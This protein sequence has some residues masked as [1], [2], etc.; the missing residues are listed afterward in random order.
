MSA[1][2]F[3][4][5]AL[6]EEGTPKK[7]FQ[8][9]LQPDD[10]M[11]YTDEYLWVVDQ[12]ARGRTI[13]RRRFQQ[14]FP[15]FEWV[16]PGERTQSLIEELKD[17]A[18]YMKLAS[19]LEQV[20]EDLSPDNFTTKA[21]F[22]REVTSDVLRQHSPASDVILNRDVAGYLRRMKDRQALRHNGEAIGISTGIK[23]LDIHLG[24]LLG[25]RTTLVLGRPGDAKSMTVAKVFVSGFLEGRVMA[26]FSPEMD[27]DEHRA[28]IA[29]LISAVPRVQEELGLQK[30]LRNR[31]LLDGTGYN[32]KTLKRLW[33]WIES[34]QGEMVLFTRKYR[35]FKMTPAFIES[36][37]ADMGVEAVFVDPIYKLR[38]SERMMK[39]SGWEKLNSIVDE[40]VDI[41]EGHNVPLWMTNQAHRQNGNRGDAP[42]KDNSFGS[43]SPVQEADAVIGVKHIPDEKKLIIRCT[44]NRWGESFRVDLKFLPNI[45]KIEDVTRGENHYYNGHED[46]SEERTRESMREMEKEMG[47]DPR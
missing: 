33:E 29:T 40:L 28:R 10:F 16:K 5:A 42:T 41:S 21:D 34:Q 20:A 23:S 19:A 9:D 43:D 39:A 47:Y 35:M 17:E 2:A 13:N 37:I 36:K 25:G 4:I 18:G 45:G 7:A 26:M 32:Y 11:L 44:K 24:G 3:V 1:E 27:E 30:A 14:T 22:L 6:V 8:A 15:E 31:A 46:G 38:P 12:A